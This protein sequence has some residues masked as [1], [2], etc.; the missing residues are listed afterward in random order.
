MWGLKL[1]WAKEITTYGKVVS[2]TT[3][4]W[5]YNIKRCDMYTNNVTKGDGEKKTELYEIKHIASY[6][7]IYIYFFSDTTGIKLIQKLILIN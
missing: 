1:C 7:Y 3:C 4:C 5:V 6:S 2:I